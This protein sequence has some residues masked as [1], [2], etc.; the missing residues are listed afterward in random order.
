M[1]SWNDVQKIKKMYGVEPDNV[2]FTC[3]KDLYSKRFQAKLPCQIQ[4]RKRIR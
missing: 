4:D 3:F 1:S 2:D